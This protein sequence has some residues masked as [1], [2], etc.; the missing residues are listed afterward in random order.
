MTPAIAP[1]ASELLTRLHSGGGWA[2]WWTLP[3]KASSWWSVGDPTPIPSGQVNVFFGVHPAGKIPERY[4]GG[5]QLRPEEMRAQIPDVVAINCLFAEFDA[6]DYGGDK[7]SVLAHIDGLALPPSVIVDSGGGYHCYW[8]LPEPFIFAGQFDRERARAA[9]S[10]WVAHAGGDKSS[11]DL[12]RVLR[13]PGTM[14]YKYSPPA[15]VAV[16]RADYGMVYDLAGLEE[17]CKPAKSLPIIGR[18]WQPSSNG[19][20]P[21]GDAGDFWLDRALNQ[22]RIG[23][24]NATG[25]WLACQLRDAGLS[26][27]EAETIMESYAGRVPADSKDPYTEAA[28]MASLR[29]AY[30][31]SPR[32]PAESAGK[33]SG[34]HGARTP[35]K[36]PPNEPSEAPAAVGE[37]FTDLGNARRLVARSGRDLRYCHPWAKWLVWDSMRWALDDTGEVARRAKGTVT[38]MYAEA[39]GADD[40]TRKATAK[41]ALRCESDARIWAMIKQAQSEP[42]I[43]ILPGNLDGDKW[44]LNTLSG[45]VDLKTGK[46]REHR[47][48]DLLT[49]MAPV[50]YEPAATCPMWLAFLD[51]IMAGNQDLI[52]FLQRAIGYALTGDTSEQVLFVLHGTGANGKSTLL[53]TVRAM[54]GSEYAIQIRPETLMI[55]QNDTIPNDVARLKGARLV[56]ARETE[57]GRRLAEG[58]VKEMT[59]G[60][61]MTARF[62]YAEHFDFR[63]EF[64]LFLAANHKPV[65]RGTDIAIWRRIRLVPF[66]V[67]IPPEEQDLG[68]PARLE[69]ELD[70]I[71]AWA[72]RGCLDWQRYGLGIPAEVRAATEAYRAESDILASFLDERTTKAPEVAAGQLYEAYKTWAESNGEHAMTGTMFGRRMAER[73]FD[74][75]RKGSLTFYLGLGVLA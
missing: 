12:A 56:N 1:D 65:I 26:Q 40:E 43:P 57:D 33:R 20:A 4:D 30:N 66:T 61:T 5:R 36:K 47:R 67:T 38:A 35:G 60:D 13:L 63:P 71:L 72:V 14:N 31:A 39:A 73:G 3:G 10:A 24:R 51:R 59:G 58:L 28:A 75:Y 18:N 11:K 8:L 68:L 50:F 16:V 74:K 44:L 64:K 6:K 52:A 15:P 7:A 69:T 23:T 55:K 53:E 45:T 22:A 2:Y 48:Q 62:L 54:L 9:Q 17:A 29:G 25:F 46:L 32:D 37:H 41:H 42:G 19:Q 49:K 21:N 27:T 34:D 70:G